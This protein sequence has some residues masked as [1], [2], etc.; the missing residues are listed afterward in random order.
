MGSD[1]HT[2]LEKVGGISISDRFAELPAIGYGNRDF[3]RQ[4][5]ILEISKILILEMILVNMN[6]GEQV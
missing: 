5:T 6:I 3:L 2:K 1:W 4:R